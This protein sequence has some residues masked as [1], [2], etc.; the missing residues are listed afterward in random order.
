MAGDGFAL[1]TVV[2]IVVGALF[3]LIFGTLIGFWACVGAVVGF[4][5]W[6]GGGVAR[7]A[8]AASPLANVVVPGCSVISGCSAWLLQSLELWHRV[9][10]QCA[11]NLVMLGLVVLCVYRD[12]ARSR[13]P[14]MN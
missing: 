2:D 5:G 12:G 11:L 3:H 1:D 13:A 10:I 6:K 7:G 4:A 8:P 14:P 9:A